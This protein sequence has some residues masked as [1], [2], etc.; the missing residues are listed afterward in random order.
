MISLLRCTPLVILAATSALAVETGTINGNMVRLRRSPSTDSKILRLLPYG[1]SVIIGENAEEFEPWV[2]V[3]TKDTTTGYIHKKFLNQ[4]TVS[5]ITQSFQEMKTTVDLQETA[6]VINGNPIPVPRDIPTTQPLTIPPPLA[7]NTSVNLT[8][9][10]TVANEIARLTAQMEKSGK[11]PK[12]EALVVYYQAIP[13]DLEK[14]RLR[15][16]VSRLEAGNDELRKQITDLAQQLIISQRQQAE[17]TTALARDKGILAALEEI[18]KGLTGNKQASSAISEYRAYVKTGERLSKQVSDETARVAD[19]LEQLRAQL[20]TSGKEVDLK[21]I[22]VVKM[23]TTNQKAIFQ[24]PLKLSNA[25][26]TLL[27]Q[28]EKDEKGGYSYHAVSIERLRY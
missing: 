18:K 22:G 19:K 24:I 28:G 5:T 25:A 10:K 15:E 17:V 12:I 26:E 16:D 13:L 20:T 2:E 23:A 21:G 27:G 8:P 3:K 7:S 4:P 11:E 6:P 14:K 9:E 1:T